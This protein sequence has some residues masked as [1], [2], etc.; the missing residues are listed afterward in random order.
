MGRFLRKLVSK[1]SASSV[2]CRAF[3]TQTR[4]Q[5]RELISD[6][7]RAEQGNGSNRSARRNETESFKAWSQNLA[8][9]NCLVTFSSHSEV[10]PR[11]WES[12]RCQQG[13]IYTPP[14]GKFTPLAYLTYENSLK[15]SSN[16]FQMKSRS[17]SLT[18][19]TLA[20]LKRFSLACGK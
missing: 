3:S 14:G 1:T 11:L 5:N 13:S 20:S 9:E 18:S 10:P 16:R 15:S 12:Q 6:L 4:K 8:H 7:I 19:L 17:S 2:V